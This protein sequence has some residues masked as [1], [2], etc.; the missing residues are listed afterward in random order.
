MCYRDNES[1]IFPTDEDLAEHPLDKK[2]K[3]SRQIKNR[4]DD[5]F[6]TNNNIGYLFSDAD[7]VKACVNECKTI[8]DAIE[9]ACPDLE[10]NVQIE[11]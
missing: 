8:K 5:V 11:E 6:W 4:L 10:G 7:L 9:A 3:I 2:K 1:D